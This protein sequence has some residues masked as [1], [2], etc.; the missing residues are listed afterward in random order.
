MMSFVE[1]FHLAQYKKINI[2]E[3]LEFRT[4]SHPQMLIFW[5]KHA[6]F[7]QGRLMKYDPPFVFSRW[8]EVFLYL[9]HDG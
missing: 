3:V 5:G 2:S 7:L 9:S 6:L 1:V 4:K 8:I